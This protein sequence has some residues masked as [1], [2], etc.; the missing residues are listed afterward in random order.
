MILGLTYKAGVNDVR[1]S[2]A[3]SVLGRLIEAGADCVYHDPYL[4]SVLVGGRRRSDRPHLAA[5]AP[6]AQRLELRSSAFDDELFANA[7]CVVILTAHPEIDYERV[8]Q[9]A[10]LVFDAVGVTRAGRHD[11]VFVL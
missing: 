4:P 9:T 5:R 11:H 3:L 6:D 1:E 8:V 7:D 2:P 10:S